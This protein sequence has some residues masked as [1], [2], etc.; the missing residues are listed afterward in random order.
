MVKY[1]RQL[2]MYTFN[3]RVLATSFF[4]AILKAHRRKAIN[5]RHAISGLFYCALLGQERETPVNFYHSAE[6]LNKSYKMIT[7]AYFLNHES[8]LL[9][10]VS[11]TFPIIGHSY[12]ESN[13]YRMELPN[14]NDFYK[15]LKSAWYNP[16]PFIIVNVEKQPEVVRNG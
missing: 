16:E 2:S 15:L 8:K 12:M 6:S 7:F 11:F 1:R 10:N 4:S 14:A 3:I 5:G 13:I 9:D